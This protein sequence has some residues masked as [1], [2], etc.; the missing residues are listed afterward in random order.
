MRFPEVAATV[1][2]VTD[3]AEIRTARLLLRRL[4]LND[5]A[6]MVDI[7]TDPETTLHR[8]AGAETPEQTRRNLDR[9]MLDWESNAIGYWAVDLLETGETIGAGGLTH[10]LEDGEPVLNLYYRFRPRT[11][12]NG[13][14][15][16]M[17]RTA[18]DWARTHRPN[19]PVSIVTRPSNAP[20][21]RVAT[22][23]GFELRAER[24]LFGFRELLFRLPDQDPTIVT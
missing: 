1:R 3:P 6:A 9:W 10:C 18:V 19:R 12:G 15:A 17:A 14:A 8:P 16:E 2:S 20:S 24:D 21:I 13:Y 11:W 5:E 4:T 7:H 23:L 22:K